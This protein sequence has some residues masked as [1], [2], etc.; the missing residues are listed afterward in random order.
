MERA[1]AVPVRRVHPNRN[2]SGLMR[3]FLHVAAPAH[4]PAMRHE[5]REL[6]PDPVIFIE[7]ER[8]RYIACG[9][10]EVEIF[11]A[12]KDVVDEVIP[13]SALDVDR[14]SR[15]ASWPEHLILPELTL[16][17]LTQVGADSVVVPDA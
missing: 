6:V 1:G 16:R 11:E 5:I 2:G 17:A 7:H 8:R 10:F 4:S 13:F 12:H 9:S 14:L 15:D 3:T